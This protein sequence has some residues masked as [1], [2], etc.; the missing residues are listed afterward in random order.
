MKR[1]EKEFN[2]FNDFHKYS[3]KIFIINIKNHIMEIDIYWS[4]VSFY[5]K[6]REMNY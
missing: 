4:S 3:I 6:S 2:K 1:K 5:G